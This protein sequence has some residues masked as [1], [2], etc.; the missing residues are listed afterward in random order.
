MEIRKKERLLY[1]L[2][3][4]HPHALFSKCYQHQYPTEF[5]K[6]EPIP[7]FII[8]IHLGSKRQKSNFFPG[9]KQ[10]PI[11]VYPGLGNSVIAFREIIQ[12]AKKTKWIRLNEL[13]VGPKIKAFDCIFLYI[14]VYKI[15]EN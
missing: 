6:T 11:E 13:L 10:L 9:K 1:L 15:S 4:L 7:G 2:Q 12:E 3:T 14:H 8:G 5:S